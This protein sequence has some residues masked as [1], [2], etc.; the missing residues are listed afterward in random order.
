MPTTELQSRIE[1]LERRVSRMRSVSVA[2]ALALAGTLLMAQKPQRP[3]RIEADEIVARNVTVES[4]LS[5][6][7]PGW[8]AGLFATTNG[9]RVNLWLQSATDTGR[10]ELAASDDLASLEVRSNTASPAQRASVQ[11]M[12][13]KAT[14]EAIVRA[15]QGDGATGKLQLKK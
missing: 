7:R 11:L 13:T 2:L 5:V 8:K 3:N 9:E 10:V 12:T 1:A 14:G 15:T 4:Q 6:Q